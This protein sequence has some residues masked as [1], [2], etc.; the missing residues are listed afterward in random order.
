MQW[1]SQLV[2]PILGCFSCISSSIF[3]RTPNL[4]G[5]EEEEGKSKPA[6]L[7]VEALC[8]DYSSDMPCYK[9]TH[10]AAELGKMQHSQSR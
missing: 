10:R 8:K 7:E 2:S 1:Y 5:Q 9:Q 3:A 6:G 4:L